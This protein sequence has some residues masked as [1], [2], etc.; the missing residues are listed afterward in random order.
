M[1]LPESFLRAA[2]FAVIL[3]RAG[4]PVAGDAE[5]GGDLFDE[6]GD[7]HMAEAIVERGDV[8]SIAD[9]GISFPMSQRIVEVAES[10]VLLELIAVRVK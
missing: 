4:F 8:V 6:G 2:S 1:L 3:E 9:E 5:I 10:C 7:V